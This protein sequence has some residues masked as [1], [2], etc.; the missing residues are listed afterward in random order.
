MQA[1]TMDN[2]GVTSDGTVNY[3]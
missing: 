3:R 2:W 1:P